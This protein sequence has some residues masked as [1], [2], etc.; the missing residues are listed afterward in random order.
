MKL[1]TF[2]TN[3]YSRLGTL[4]EKN[5]VVDLNYAFQALLQSKGKFRSETIA[6][7]YVP[8]D[9]KGFIE[10][11]EESLNY[12]KE[13][14]DFA[15]AKPDVF[16]HQLIYKK[17]DVKIEAPIQ[18]PGKM[19]CVG[20]NYEEHIKEMGRDLPENPVVFA[21]FDNTIVGPEDDIVHYPISD[22]LDYEAELAF[23]IGKEAKNVSEADAL[24]YVAGYTIVN[25]VTYRDIQ[26][27]TLQW[28][29]GKTVDGTAPMG[30]WIM[31]SDEL[32]DPDGLELVLT[33]NGE[34]MQRSN[35]SNHVFTVQ[36]LVAFLSGLA[37]LKPGDI[38][39]TGTPG[40]VGSARDPQVFMKDGDVVK[41]EIDK[42]GALE[43]KVVAENIQK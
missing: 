25:D 6:E 41:I 15:Q 42:I 24:N 10:G 30:P 12:A 28:L 27:R 3:G 16:N 4:T 38:V 7:A 29:Q 35:T 39:L 26:Q 43:N 34:E 36:K 32:Q 18:N 14:I 2:K 8:S 17:E 5:E 31:T 19:F 33:L 37:T 40:G 11:G 21:K 9:A 22:K 1:I 13:A 23:V 20:H